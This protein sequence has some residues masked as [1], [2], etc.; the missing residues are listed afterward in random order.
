MC[1]FLLDSGWSGSELFNSMKIYPSIFISI[2]SDFTDATLVEYALDLVLTIFY[3]DLRRSEEIVEDDL[4]VARL[5]VERAKVEH[6]GG[7][8]FLA[9][10]LLGT[11]WSPPIIPPAL[12]YLRKQDRID[13][14]L[15]IM[16]EETY[17]RVGG[18]NTFLNFKYPIA[19]TL[20]VLLSCGLGLANLG[21]EQGEELILTRIL[22]FMFRKF[23]DPEQQ[24]DGFNGVV[25]E[26]ILLIRSGVDPDA[27]FD[28]VDWTV[29]ELVMLDPHFTEVAWNLALA[30]SGWK[31]N[32]DDITDETSSSVSSMDD[33]FVSNIA[34]STSNSGYSEEQVVLLDGGDESKHDD[35]KG[36]AAE[37]LNPPE[38][39]ENSASPKIPGA[40]IEEE[41]LFPIRRK[42]K[43]KRSDF[44]GYYSGY[45]WPSHMY[46]GN[47]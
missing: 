44:D 33:G 11:C 34:I 39:D 30:L 12:E 41:P 5:L 19:T 7:A 29:A 2:L 26:L 3:F 27:H 17:S 37:D 13:F 40:W 35:E 6:L 22:R 21:T 20:R 8:N 32:G 42:F 16:M 4:K 43:S 36:N 24:R 45:F 1:E 14:D 38:F 18:T 47:E 46:I 23:E 10:L 31:N 28:S 9:G 15:K 25:L